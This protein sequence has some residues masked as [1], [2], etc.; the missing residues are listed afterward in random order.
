V[1]IRAKKTIIKY[2]LLFVGLII[3]LITLIPIIWVILTAFKPP[4]LTFKIPP[5]FIYKPTLDGFKMLF[6]TSQQAIGVNV[7]KSLNNSVVIAV[8]STALTLILGCF[9]AFSLVNFRFKFRKTISFAI[10][11]T[12]MLPPIGTIVPFFLLVNSLH[13]LDTQFALIMAY[14]ALNLPL[15]VWMLRGFMSDI[16]PSLI[17]AALTDGCTYFVLLGRIYV[18]V[19]LPGL[20]ATGVFSFL[21]SWNDFA[22]AMTLSQSNARTLPLLAMSFITEEGTLWGPMAA[23]I[24]LTI[25]PPIILVMLTHRGLARGLTFG[26]VKE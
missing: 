8:V 1:E 19:I 3:A 26:A 17:E 21:L 12:R 16:P 14:T 9:A 15:T 11:A 25:I 4:I 5:A 7:F 10:L 6:F 18:P 20:V 2:V 13:L 24:T 23:A 22:I